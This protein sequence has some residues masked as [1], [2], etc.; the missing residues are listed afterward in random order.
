[1]VFGNRVGGMILNL[2]KCAKNTVLRIPRLSEG[3]ELQRL[4]NMLMGRCWSSL[5]LLWS[6]LNEAHCG[7]ACD[8][9]KNPSFL[10]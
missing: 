10:L 4:E 8:R 9:E 6:H 2:G 3:R 5:C 1:M 7:R